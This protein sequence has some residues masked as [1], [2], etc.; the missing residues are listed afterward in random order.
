MDKIRLYVGA[1][2]FT[3]Q[4]LTEAFHHESAFVDEVPVAIR[5]TKM[6]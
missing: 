4:E 1:Y 6:P 3:D 2:S 5:T